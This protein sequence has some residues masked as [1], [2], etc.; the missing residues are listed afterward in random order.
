[1]KDKNKAKKIVSSDNAE[2]YYW[3]SW[4]SGMAKDFLVLHPAASMNHSSL[5]GL[6]K[7]INDMGHPTLVFDQRGTGYSQVG[8]DSDSHSLD[9]YAED[10][11]RIIEQEGL[12]KPWIITHSFGFMPAVNYASKSGNVGKITGICVSHNFSKTSNPFLFQLFS[13]GL[14]YMEYPGCAGTYLWHKV[15]GEK[16]GD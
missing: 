2:I 10:L 1:M 11:Q 9:R 5:Q 15:N 6:E 14:I 12:E 13:K 16:R 4:N 3:I 7:G 8:S